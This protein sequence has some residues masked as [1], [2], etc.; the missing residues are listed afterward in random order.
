MAIFSVLLALAGLAAAQINGK[1][2]LAKS[3]TSWDWY[4]EIVEGK[5]M[6]RRKSLAA[7]KKK[8]TGAVTAANQSA[9]RATTATTSSPLAAWPKSAT[10]AIT[11]WDP[12]PV[13]GLHRGAKMGGPA[14]S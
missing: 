6:T 8:L 10:G 2:T 3:Y 7:V 4:V 14:S 5:N 11:P 9:P 13:S 1:L 12:P